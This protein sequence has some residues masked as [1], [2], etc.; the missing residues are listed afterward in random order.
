MFSGQDRG[1]DIIFKE[2]V[3]MGKPFPEY[4]VYNDSVSLTIRSSTE[5]MA[6][7]K[8]IVQEQ[9]KQQK[10]FPLSELMIMRYLADNKRIKL[11]D[12]HILIQSS[13]EEAKKSCNNLVKMGFIESIGKDYMLTAKVYDAIKTDVEYAQDQ[14]V[15]YIKAKDRILE[16]LNTNEFIKNEKIQ[17]L[18]GF[19]RQ[20]VRMTTEKMRSEDLIE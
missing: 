7:V 3:S 8:F 6:F 16:Y 4:R 5:D 17:E 10:I 18:C 13:L 20:Q 9:D 14:I 1:V 19:T 2:M 15:R 11:S 12:A